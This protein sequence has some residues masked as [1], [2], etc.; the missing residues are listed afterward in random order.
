MPTRANSVAAPWQVLPQPCPRLAFPRRIQC[1]ARLG[2]VSNPFIARQSR[3][4]RPQ[5]PAMGEAFVS[6][7]PLGG[8]DGDFSL[9]P[10][11]SV[12]SKLRKGAGAGLGGVRAKTP[13]RVHDATLLPCCCA[14]VLIVKLIV[15]V[16]SC[17][18]LPSLPLSLSSQGNLLAKSSSMAR[19]SCWRSWT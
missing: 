6:L 3:K 15:D 4:S 19:S 7:K 5:P 2:S 14:M 17:R 12:F 10:S 11:T 9:R 1:N 16:C 8:T 18:R 13:V